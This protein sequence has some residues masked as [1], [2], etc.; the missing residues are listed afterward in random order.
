M[1]P[2]DD[3]HLLRAA[4]GDAEAFDALARPR[5]PRMVRIA[6]RIVGDEADAQD[7]AQQALLRLWQTLDRFRPGEDLDGWIYR[8]VVNLAL[9][10]LR[11]RRSRPEGSAATAA[12]ADLGLRDASAGPEERVLAA[13]LE[14]A[15]QD[16]TEG[17]APRQKA[18]FVLTRVEGLPAADV[19]A[20]L[21]ITPS[22]VRNTLFQARALIAARL[23]ERYPGLLAPFERQG[24]GTAA[25]GGDDDGNGNDDDGGRTR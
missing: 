20:L 6:A 16:V 13:E 24:G 15:L 25:V 18:V 11:R 3:R 14:R 1:L 23:R 10:S 2:D 4:R 19:A 5:W 21:G 8:M 9:D 7:V 12:P 17:L 22:T